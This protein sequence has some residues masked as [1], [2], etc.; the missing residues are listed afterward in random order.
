MIVIYKGFLLLIS[1]K[2]MHTN[3]TSI[4]MEVISNLI[5]VGFL[6]ELIFRGYIGTRLFGYFKNKILSI[7]VV[8]IMFAFMHIPYRFVM[9]NMTFYDFMNVYWKSFSG[10]FIPHLFLQWL[11]SKYNSIIAPTMVH[12]IW[13]LL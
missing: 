9:S 4:V 6:E 5:F 7:I 1:G 12:F 3:I 8:G 11:Y 2:Q 13:D 10:L